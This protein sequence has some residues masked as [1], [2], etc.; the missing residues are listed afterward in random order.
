MTSSDAGEAA[1][2]STTADPREPLNLLFRDLRTSEAGL[3]GRE[4]QRRLLVYGPNELPRTSG[5]QWPGELLKKVTHPLA[6]VL[7]VAAALA[8]LT[9]TPILAAAIIAVIALNAGFAFVQEMQAERAVEARAA[10][11]NETGR[12]HLACRP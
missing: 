6:V 10:T 4:A 11:P 1:E 7:V 5:R 3:S 8:W 2:A 9:G 12:D